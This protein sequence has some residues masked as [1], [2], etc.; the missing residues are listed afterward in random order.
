LF[1]EN[2]RMGGHDPYSASKGAAELVSA[3][4]ARSFLIPRRQR[5]LMLR[6]GNVIGGGDY[7]SNRLIVDLVTQLRNE[8]IPQIRNPNA[9]RPWQY[10]LDA[11]SGYI[12]GVEY[13]H[14][15]ADNY[16]EQFNIG[17]K[18]NERITVSELAVMFC[19]L[20]NG[21]KI[22]H[23]PCKEDA[24]FEKEFLGLD[25]SKALSTLDWSP[26]YDLNAS[27]KSTVD[28]YRKEDSGETMFQ[29]TQDQIFE[30]L[31]TD[32]EIND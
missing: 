28:W 16:F 3:S 30:Y 22:I 25:V 17:P 24:F 11:L 1:S 8:K 21:K 4:F 20:W 31:N 23:T 6:G 29:F 5:C 26:K 19:D 12:S 32:V 9:I 27:I 10:V 7:G 15:T 2:D 13:I 14:V 18:P